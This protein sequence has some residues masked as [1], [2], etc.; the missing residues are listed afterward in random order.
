[1]FDRDLEGSGMAQADP[2]RELVRKRELGIAIE[3]LMREEAVVNHYATLGYRVLSTND[4]E[5]RSLFKMS[6]R[7]PAADVVAEVTKHRLI[8]AE[9]KGSDVGRALT[10]LENTARFAQKRYPCVECKIFVKNW[11][12]RVDAVDIRG[13][14]C[15][16]RGVRVFKAGFPGEWLLYAYDAAGG[17]SLIR[18]ASGNV[19]V[20]FGPHV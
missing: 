9:V 16:F 7:D 4:D 8:I 15:G 19:T 17:T 11:A 5:T 13:G 12:P 1:M 6:E 3:A 18:I 14:H 10:Q 2:H 20:V